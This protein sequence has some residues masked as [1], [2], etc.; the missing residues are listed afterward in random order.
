MKEWTSAP[1]K[2]A[3]RHLCARFAAAIAMDRG[4][5]V[6][7]EICI[8]GLLPGQLRTQDITSLIFL[9]GTYGERAT[10]PRAPGGYKLVD[11]IQA[12]GLVRV[13]ANMLATWPI[14]FRAFLQEVGGYG[15]QNV[16][17]HEP[18]TFFLA[19]VKALRKNQES[20]A[21]KFI[22]TEY[23]AFMTETWRGLIDRRHSWATQDCRENQSYM[24]PLA[25]S[26][27]LRVAR[28]QVADLVAN[29]ILRGVLKKLRADELF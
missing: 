20:P 14:S 29:N 2:E 23:E 25:A 15:R 1:V 9:L 17:A 26:R 7:E 3:E 13:A 19:F 6:D 11:P 18:P 10:V 5:P 22:V 12:H 21:L 28:H 24:T 16:V 4:M 27:A 8:F